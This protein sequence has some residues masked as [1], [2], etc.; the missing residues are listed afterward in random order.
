MRQN[1]IKKGGRDDALIRDLIKEL[2][3]IELQIFYMVVLDD[4]AWKYL[5]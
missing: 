4:E 5:Q 2:I 1:C 3:H